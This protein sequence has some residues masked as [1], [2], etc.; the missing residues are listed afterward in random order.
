MDRL[1]FFS[2]QV[3]FWLLA[4]PDGH[5]KNFSVFIERG[6][7]FRMT[8]LYDIM[9]AYP[10]LGHGKNLIAP[11]KLKLAMAFTGKNRHYEWQKIGL[12]HIRETAR[13]CGMGDLID[14]EITCIIT[15]IPQAVERLS[16]ELPKGFPEDVAESVFSGLMKRGRLLEGL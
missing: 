4:A 16:T 13:L 7:R 11:E 1:T 9:S 8:P 14:R 3:V 5:A 10:V 2:A 15:A 12:R 6:G